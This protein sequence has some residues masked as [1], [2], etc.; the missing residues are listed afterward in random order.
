M[1]AFK[2]CVWRTWVAFVVLAL[3]IRKHFVPT[4]GRAV[5]LAR[6]GRVQMAGRE[7]TGSTGAQVAHSLLSSRLG[8]ETGSEGPLL[9]TVP[10]WPVL[11]L[12]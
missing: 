8:L 1:P 5:P 6:A 2:A 4:C 10:R 12:F 11:V 7:G 9:A 3:R